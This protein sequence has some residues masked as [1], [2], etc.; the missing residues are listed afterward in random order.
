MRFL[1]FF[2]PIFLFA[3][4]AEDTLSQMSLEEKIG[5]LFAAPACPMRGEDHWDDWLELREKYRIGNAILKQGTA[6]E[7]VRFLNRLQKD[8]KVPFLILADAEWGLAMR[9]SD[10]I[11]FPKN[12]TLGAVTDLEK[13]SALGAEIGRQAKR[14]GIHMNLAPVADVNNNPANP[15]I[16]TRSFG[17]DPEQVA[18]RVS[19][20]LKGMQ[21]EGIMG[22]VKHFPGHGDT[23]V[24]SHQDL[25]SIPFSRERLEKVEF[26]P[27]KQAIEDGAAGILTAHL[28]VP[29]IDKATP[30]SLSES[31]LKIPREKWGFQG[32][33]VSDAL[34]MKAIADRYTPEEIA[35]LARKAGCDILLYGN[36]KDPAVDQLIQEQIP[37]A[38][39]ALKEEYETDKLDLEELDQSV[40]R[41]LKAKEKI[42]RQIPEE[43]LF[44]ALHSQEAEGLKRELFLD[45]VTQVGEP[46]SLTGRYAYISI[47]DN[48]V[49]KGQFETVLTEKDDWDPFDQ[50]IIALHGVGLKT[51]FSEEVMRLIESDRSIV[52]LFGTPYALKK[53]KKRNSI[54]IGYENDSD[55][56]WAVYSVLIGKEKGKGR[57]PVQL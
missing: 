41:I 16:H 46:I 17:E 56:Q 52:L 55:A 42:E 44:D 47:G 40:L 19:A 25:P 38:F 15:V 36:H 14:V 20:F 26:V 39:L 3:G 12:M 48:D 34:N 50:I 28:L 27:F 10:T 6:I 37:R 2:T 22:C 49:L 29:C 35:I 1:I 43:G 8:A 45:A 9:L 23:A 21:G 30:T 18:S 24:D 7:Q 51:E 57:L 31:C 4:W 33:I 11:A 54:L 32:L 5:Q 13:I 53:F